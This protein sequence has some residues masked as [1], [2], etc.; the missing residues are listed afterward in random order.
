MM[1]KL[2]AIICTL[3]ILATAVPT[4]FAQNDVLV[5]LS[6]FESVDAGTVMENQV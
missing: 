2:L 6:D 1:K 4:V 5:N 3:A